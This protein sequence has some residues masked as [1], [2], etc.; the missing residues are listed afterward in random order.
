[1]PAINAYIMGN[2]QTPG[3]AQFR[4]LI[5]LAAAA[6]FAVFGI[7]SI[8]H[9][10]DYLHA[11]GERGG[12]DIMR[13]V[14]QKATLTYW[15]FWSALAALSLLLVASKRTAWVA[16]FLCLA[17]LTE[18]A[19]QG[20]FVA[21][22]GH[23]YQPLPA[24]SYAMFDPNPVTLASPHPGT[25]VDG[26]S[27]DANHR[28]T[29]VNEGKVAD[30][31]L[32]YVFGG[33]TTYDVGNRDSD[34]WPSQLSRLLGSA[35]AVENYGVPG[36]SSM[37]ALAQSLFAFRDAHVSCAVY[38]EGWNDLRNAH[39]AGLQSDYSDYEIPYLN[40]ALL[41]QSKPG[42]L[43]RNSLALAYGASLLAPAKIKPAGQVSGEKDP[44]LSKIYEDNI[45]LLAAIGHSFGVTVVFIPQIVNHA[46]L[47]QGAPDDDRLVESFI[48]RQAMGHM[49]DFM[50]QDLADVAAQ[51][52]AVFLG[53]VEAVP[54]S[55]EDFLD[56]VHFAA[57]G[58]LKF[59]ETIAP[60]LRRIC[61]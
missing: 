57:K 51:S 55:S 58:S 59:A 49:V 9:Y 40:R 42:F 48:R 38:Y 46:L 28:R 44:R 15:L 31:K 13:G 19:A 24:I 8:R 5:L 50:N 45:G 43:Q 4:I 12:Q 60:D 37:E 1:L 54:W 30:P 2:T 22:H 16:Y 53:A 34:T 39:I 36:F 6:A 26:L 41:L 21:G 10:L 61:N 23:L 7:E 3:F 29:T 17:I 11:V 27:H 18:G 33:S 14:Q 32:I 47:K 56:T 25:F 52:Q 20:F 35:Y